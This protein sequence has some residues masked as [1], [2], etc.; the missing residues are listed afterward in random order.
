MSEHTDPTDEQS[1]VFIDGMTGQT[2]GEYSSWEDA[3]D[4]MGQAEETANQHLVDAQRI[5]GTSP[6]HRYWARFFP[7]ERLMIFGRADTVEE[8]IE[9]EKKYFDA[10][11][12]DDGW[13]EHRKSIIA[14]DRRGYLFG[15]AWSVMC[16]EG[17]LGSTHRSEVVEIT[18]A[19]WEAFR[20]V[21]WDH[22]AVDRELVVTLVRRLK[23]Q[24]QEALRQS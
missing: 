14:R 21:G 13:E 15:R 22:T 20:Q 2:L 10:D 8:Q 7:V 5:I 3:L 17:E 23:D 1:V 18:E 11:D 6:E 4:A 12:P 24:L 19:E 16:P 9:T